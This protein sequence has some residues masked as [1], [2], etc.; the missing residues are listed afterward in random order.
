MHTK[1]LLSGLIV[2]VSFTF[3]CSCAVPMNSDFLYPTPTDPPPDPL[4][5]TPVDTAAHTLIVTIRIDEDQDATDHTSN[6]SFQFRTDVI[7]ENN[8]V[9]FDDEEHVFCNGA[10]LTLNNLQTYTLKVPRKDGYKCIYFG[11]TKGIGPLAAVPMIDVV[12]RSELAPQPPFVDGKGYKIKYNPDSSDLACSITA[13]ARDASNN[14]PGH[15]ST[16]DVGIYV[17]P[18]TNTLSGEGSILL[19]RTCSWQYHNPFDTINVIYQ[20]T[21]SVEVTWTH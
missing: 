12:A 9:K 2:L 15:A 8:Y 14:I 19:Q 5:V 10:L 20:S 13:D 1:H 7:E 6:I 11:D 17:G 3:L 4:G 18:A 21:A 16:S